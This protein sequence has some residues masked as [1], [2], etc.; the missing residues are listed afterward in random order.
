MAVSIQ[1]RKFPEHHLPV[2]YH[3]SWAAIQWV[4]SHVNGNGPEAWLNDHADF[5]RVFLAGDSAGANIAHNMVV[6]VEDDGLPGVRI[7]GMNLMHPF[8][9]NNEPDKLMQYIFPS[10]SGCNDPLLN[11]AIYPEKLAKLVCS[12][13]LICVSE[14][15]WMRD[16]GWTYCKALRKSG[17]GSSVE[18]VEI[19]GESHVFHLLKPEGENAVDLMNRVASFLTHE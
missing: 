19:E 12:K 13:V 7:V 11:P 4:A 15:D 8:F 2:A 10:S 3:D 14:K 17:W 1:Y 5:Q 9:V 6:K 16:R 18:I